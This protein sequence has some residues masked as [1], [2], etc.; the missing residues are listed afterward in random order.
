M[1]TFSTS[2]NLTERTIT[3]AQ[4]AGKLS[5]GHPAAKFYLDTKLRGFGLAV[6]ATG[7]KSFFVMRR[8]RGKKER[9]VFGRATE[10]TVTEARAKAEKLLPQMTD[11]VSLNEKRRRD[12][13]EAKRVEV[14]GVTLR[15]AVALYE[16]TLRKNGRAPRTIEDYRY[17]LEK[18]L[19]GWLDRPL[20]EIT[21]AEVRKRHDEIPR[22]IARGKHG[23]KR[24]GAGKLT[25][26]HVMRA[27]RA[28]YNRAVREHPELPGNPIIN[29]DWNP[30]H[31]RTSRIPEAGL[32]AWYD[33]VQA[34][35][36]PVRRDYL[37]FALFTGLRKEN[38]AEPRWEHVDWERRALHV[39]KPKS[40]KPFDLPLSNFLLDV[41]R[42]R[43]E[44]NKVL[45][46]DS[47]WVFPAAWGKGHLVEV[48]TA[49]GA[50]RAKGVADGLPRYTPHDLRRT[51][52]SVA[53]S[54]GISREARQLLVNHATPKSDVHGGY[55]VP[56]LDALR[57]HMQTIA[58]R[59]L[60]LCQPPTKTT[61][62]PLR[63]RA[64]GAR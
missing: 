7:V 9:H 43:Q 3:A 10:L 15:D 36:N 14:R 24:P 28:V 48:R 53:E 6:S 52:I 55:V 13:A 63:K 19:A 49:G 50:M 64:K 46:P 47:P 33:G 22:E 54:L 42:R 12:R 60:A 11:G 18:Y 31:R 21:R 30:E 26:N 38:A 29:V 25:A 37:L 32:K 44:E 34:L 61:V 5:G 35:K 59:L 41:L 16:G 27:F 45:A 57:A 40:Q 4:P 8:V 2:V 23:P 17:L 51:F 58:D 20:A 62:V 39:P 56:E 1:G